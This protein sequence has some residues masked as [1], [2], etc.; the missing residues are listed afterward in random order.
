MDEVVK[1]SSLNSNN[2]YCFAVAPTNSESELEPIGRTCRD[3]RTVNPLPI[4]M[5]AAIIAKTGYQINE[6]EL[7]YSAAK[8]VIEEICEQSFYHTIDERPN[9]IYGYKFKEAAL[10]NMSLL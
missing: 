1:V 5:L 7:A 4:P 3:I 6:Y 9:I 2:V 8:I 10:K